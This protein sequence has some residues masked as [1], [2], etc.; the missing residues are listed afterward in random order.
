MF[1]DGKKHD[2]LICHSAADT[3]WAVSVLANTLQN[4]YHHTVNLCTIN[5]TLGKYPF[6]NVYLLKHCKN[7]ENNLCNLRY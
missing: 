5:N 2:V 7:R 3:E 6:Y 1:L 4:Q